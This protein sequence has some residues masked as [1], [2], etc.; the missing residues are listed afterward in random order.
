VLQYRIHP[1]QVSVRR[2]K[3][4]TLSSLAT[5]A[6]AASRRNGNLDP[7]NSVEEVTPAVLVGLGVSEAKQQSAL[8]MEYRGWIHS[9][10]G[11]GEWL[12]ALNA[13]IEMLRSSDWKHMERR[14]MADMRLEVAGL[15]WKNKRYLMSIITVGHA[16]ITRPMVAGR[17]LRPWLRRFGLVR[18]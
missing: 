10:C 4:Q 2:R 5:L 12:G 7:L 15:Y 16:V 13:A 18:A 11:A 14:T 1:H 8:A 17:P 9:M 3:Q 6:S